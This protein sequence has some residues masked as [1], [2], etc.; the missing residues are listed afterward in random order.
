LAAAT[1]DGHQHVFAQQAKINPTSSYMAE[2]LDGSKAVF[3]FTE[4]GPKHL[5]PKD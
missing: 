1:R 2:A 4:P 5:K 3:C